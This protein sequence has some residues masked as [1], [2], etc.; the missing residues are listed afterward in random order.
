MWLT[1]SGSRENLVAKEL[2]QCLDA[3]LSTGLDE[4]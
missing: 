2:N 3:Q 1:K 4:V